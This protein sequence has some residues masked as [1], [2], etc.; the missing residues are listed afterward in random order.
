[1]ALGEYLDTRA[2]LGVG[3]KAAKRVDK[4]DEPA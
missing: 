4:L 3:N 1:M 2:Q